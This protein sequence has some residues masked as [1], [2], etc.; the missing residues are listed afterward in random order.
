MI[1]FV[2]KFPVLSQIIFG[3]EPYK[4]FKSIKSESKVISEKSNFLAVWK[5]NKSEASSSPRNLT[6]LEFGKFAKS[7]LIILGDMF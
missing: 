3:G 5:I 6:W 4:I 2:V 1:E 7:W